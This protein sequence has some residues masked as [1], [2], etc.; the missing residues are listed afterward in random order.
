MAGGGSKGRRSLVLRYCFGGLLCLLAGINVLLGSAW[1]LCLGI[2]VA[3]GIILVA[4]RRI[5]HAAV[6]RSADEIVCRYIPWYEG[7]AYSTL[8]L[9][10]LLGVAAI[11]AGSAPGHP[12]WLRL[13][14]IAILGV[15]P[16]TFYGVLRMWLRSLLCITPSV[17]IVRVAERRS[18][19]IEIRRQLVQSIEPKLTPRP[20]GGD[21][22]QVAIAHRPADATRDTSKTVIV[23]LRLSVQPINLLH[24]L[25]AWN[26]GA[27]DNPSQLLDRIERILRGHSTAGV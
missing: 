17:L 13:A 15:T 16:L 19:S 26:D 12:A 4:Q 23:G 6:S 3:G 9:V 8:V 1:Y 25:V 24:A 7:N 22:L 27:Q 10:P 21:W 18:E 11:A 2:A 14:G 20:A 5:F